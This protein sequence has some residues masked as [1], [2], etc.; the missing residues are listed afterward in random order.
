MSSTASNDV[1]DLKTAAGSVRTVAMEAQAASVTT[2][3]EMMLLKPWGSDA[4]GQAFAAVYL[5]GATS[6]MDAVLDTGPQLGQ[7]ADAL[8]TS[9][10]GYADTEQTNQG[11]ASSVPTGATVDV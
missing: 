2:T 8:A 3:V 1:S 6:V 9:A 10:G 5:P 4:V 7:I 11:A